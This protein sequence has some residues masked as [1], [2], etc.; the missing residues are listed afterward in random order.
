MTFEQFVETL[1]LTHFSAEE[2][3]TKTTNAENEPPPAE[4]WEQ[5]APTIL[6]VQEVRTRFDRAIRFNS[7]YR[8]IPYNRRVG[9]VKLSPHIAFCA[10]DFRTTNETVL[11]EMYH[12]LNGRAG[13]WIDA[14]RRFARSQVTVDGEAISQQPLEWRRQGGQEQFMFRGGLSLYSTFIHLDT[15][16]FDARW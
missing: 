14:P 8:N 7:V 1:G 13:S 4:I 6:I 2:L 3:L 16:G 12:Y 5:I 15:R 10:V 11:A 9:G